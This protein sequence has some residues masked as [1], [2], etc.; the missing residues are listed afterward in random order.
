MRRR[1]VVIDYDALVSPRPSLLYPELRN[2]LLE[3]LPDRWI[4]AYR[5]M[6]QSPTRIHRF[7]QQGF[8]ILF[9]RASEL[10]SRGVLSGDRAVEDRVIAVY[11]N[12]QSLATNSSVKRNLLGDAAPQFGEG[13]GKP[14]LRGCVLGG[15]FGISL[16]PQTRDLDTER[17]SEARVY[18]NMQ[19]YCE[20]HP[21]TLSFTRLIYRDRTW[22]PSAIEHGLLKEDGSFWV[23]T[24]RNAPEGSRIPSFLKIQSRRTADATS[25]D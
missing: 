21:G 13:K 8:E 2:H 5:K 25:A 23:H 6:A 14:Y 16:Y 19:R 17:S 24:F 15:R 7:Q 12:S 22:H 9:D 10:R 3:R 4:K 1:G 18:R 20:E 11:G